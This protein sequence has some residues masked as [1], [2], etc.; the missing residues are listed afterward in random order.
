[1]YVI[2]IKNI[3]LQNRVVFYISELEGCRQGL[4]CSCGLDC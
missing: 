3:K 2:L 4:G 1:M